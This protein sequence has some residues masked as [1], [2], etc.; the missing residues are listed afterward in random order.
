MLRDNYAEDKVFAEILQL[1]PFFCR[2]ESRG[3]IFWTRTMCKKNRSGETPTCFV[4][5]IFF[6]I[7]NFSAVLYTSPNLS[8]R[9]LAS[10]LPWPACAS[11]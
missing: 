4:Y 7:E 11:I 5:P 8:A 9:A 1:V 2:R 3:T 10:A 6:F